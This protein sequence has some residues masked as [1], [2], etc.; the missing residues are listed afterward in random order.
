[1]TTLCLEDLDLII[2]DERLSPIRA[3]SLEQVEAILKNDPVEEL[4]SEGRWQKA[5]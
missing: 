3:I 4:K 2:D 5:S 1:M